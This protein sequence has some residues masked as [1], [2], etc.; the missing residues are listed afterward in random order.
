MKGEGGTRSRPLRQSKE[1]LDLLMKK[2]KGWW[3]FARQMVHVYVSNYY[4]LFSS[5]LL[6]DQVDQ[7]KEG[8]NTILLQRS[9]ERYG[10]NSRFV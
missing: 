1:E 10:D 6:T 2:Q 5:A 7:N 8:S 3:I 9:R 4:E